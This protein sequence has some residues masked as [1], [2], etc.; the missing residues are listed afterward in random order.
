MSLGFGEGCESCVGGGREGDG[1]RCK[2]F[3]N[4][5]IFDFAMNLGDVREGNLRHEVVVVVVVR[6]MHRD[7]CLKKTNVQGQQTCLKRGGAVDRRPV[8]KMDGV[9]RY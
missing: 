5:H 2:R 3:G 7:W 9:N 4:G 8:D 1:V 6:N